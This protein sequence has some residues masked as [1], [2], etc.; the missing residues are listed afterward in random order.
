MNYT[1]IYESF[2]LDRQG[3][4]APDGYAE[5]HHIL[6]RSLG[7]SNKSENLIKLTSGDH[8]F[9]HL[10]LAKIFGGKMWCALNLMVICGKYKGRTSR[11]FYDTV[12]RRHSESISG[13]KNPF[14]GKVHTESARG[15]I[16]AKRATQVISVESR[17]KQA[18]AMRGRKQSPDHI[19]KR[20]IAQQGK[21][22]TAERRQKISDAAKQLMWIT[23]G[24]HN[25]RVRRGEIPDGWS[26]G[27]S[28]NGCFLSK[29]QKE[30]ILVNHISTIN[31]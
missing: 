4:P 22:F 17:K 28:K 30:S 5:L 12:R 20:K 27:I 15:R 19:L 13:N 18:D 10:L 21:P 2:I 11:L 31:L 25:A 7:G 23:D 8:L 26:R 24:L 29:D 1:K 9:A 6:P 3:K 16:A 14:F